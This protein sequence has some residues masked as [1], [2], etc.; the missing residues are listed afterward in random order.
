MNKIIIDLDDL[1]VQAEESG[2]FIIDPKAEQCLIKIMEAEQSIKEIRKLAEAIIESKA[3]AL[4]PN[5]TS[6]EGD[7]VRVTYRAYGNKYLID[8]SRLDELLPHL[9]KKTVKLSAVSKEVDKFFKEQGELPLGIIEKDRD[10]KI[11]L[12]LLVGGEASN[13]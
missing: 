2:D 7:N 8:E 1:T 9:Y 13:D 5:F 3:K 4:D 6:I 11:S 10:K 12:K